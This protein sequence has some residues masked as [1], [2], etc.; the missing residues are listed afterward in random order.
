MTLFEIVCQSISLRLFS[1]FSFPEDRQLN[2][3]H[4]IELADTN[5]NVNVTESPEV[6]SLLRL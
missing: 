2:L 4:V 6:L 3:M 5:T 1:L